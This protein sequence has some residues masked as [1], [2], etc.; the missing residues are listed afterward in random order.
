MTARRT[1]LTALLLASGFS[2]LFAVVLQRSPHSGIVDFRIVYLAARCMIEH[3]DPYSPNEYL[4]VFQEQGGTVP[5]DPVERQRFEGAVMAVVYLPTALLLIA[6]FA[7]LGWGTAQALWTLL[8]ISLF[9]IACCL[10]WKVAADFSPPLAA[11]MVGFMLANAEVVFAFGNAAGVAVSLC[12]IAVWCF[13]TERFETAGIVCL[14]LSLAIKPHDSAAVWLWLLIVGGKH[15]RWAGQSFLVVCGVGILAA[16]WAY[17]VSPHWLEELHSNLEIV[18]ARGGVADPG[19][20]G[21]S[22]GTGGT[23]INLQAV[24][25]VFRDDPGLYNMAAYAVCAL[26]FIAWLIRTFR[27]GRSRTEMWL[28]LA[29]LVPLSMLPVYHRSYDAKLL[30]LAIPAC[31]ALWA[32]GGAQR[33]VATLTTSAAIL[34]TS[35]LPSTILTVMSRRIP[36]NPAGFSEQ[37]LTVVVARPAPLVLLAMAMFYLSVY[38]RQ[39]YPA[40]T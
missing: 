17:Q 20:T 5:A 18:S 34:V 35:D 9:T 23:I 4:R 15:R 19:P 11:I 24:F 3:R 28:A 8:T 32:Q 40:A 6:P 1:G 14:A 22:N 38:V 26:L 13:I 7:V 37:L 21:M 2:T 33:W 36:A 16:L 27:G 10:I 29:A 31:A 25:S 12:A 39:A 30:L